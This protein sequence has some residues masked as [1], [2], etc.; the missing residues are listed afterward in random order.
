MLY[1]RNRV[2]E[3]GTE[4]P[5]VLQR[6]QQSSVDPALQQRW[7][8]LKAQAAGKE[9]AHRYQGV[10][11]GRVASSWG[12]LVPLIHTR[13][14]TGP[15]DWGHELSLGVAGQGRDWAR[16][17]LSPPHS[18]M[19]KPWEAELGFPWALMTHSAPPTPGS[20]PL[21]SQTR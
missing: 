9:Q 8:G 14:T 16:G 10:P 19:S 11:G 1:S 13:A 12:P 18:G 21:A 3:A 6:R 15:E 20:K 4:G 7:Q 17:F 5:A 2:R